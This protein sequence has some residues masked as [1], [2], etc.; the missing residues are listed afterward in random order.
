[1]KKFLAVSFALAALLLSAGV[2]ADTLTFS[3]NFF[4]GKTISGSFNGMLSGDI[5]DVSSA[6]PIIYNGTSLPVDPSDIRSLSDFP[7]GALQPTVSL[8]GL[9][10]NQDIFVC[11]QGFTGGNCSFSSEGGFFFGVFGAAAG[12]ALNNTSFEQ[13]DQS[14]WHASVTAVPEPETFAM[15]L[16]GLGSMGAIARRRKAKLT[17]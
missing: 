5:F 11:A 3:Y 10:A 7:S 2:K 17:A 14:R 16:V 9:Q 1:M 4:D 6:N 8:S 13:Y 12:D 15:M